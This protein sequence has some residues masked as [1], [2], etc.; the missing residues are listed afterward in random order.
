MLVVCPASVVEN[1]KNELDR[2]GHFLVEILGKTTATI[3][4][5]LELL[6]YGRT[7]ILLTSYDRLTTHAAVLSPLTWDV[8][9]LDEAHQLKNRKTQL[10]ESV[11]KF[12]K[13]RMRVAL[14]GTPIQNRLGELWALLYLLHNKSFMVGG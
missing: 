4:S 1:W 11:S 5:Q 10:Y 12:T 7:E 3:D 8:I 13:A 2:W 14:T 9:V 6:R